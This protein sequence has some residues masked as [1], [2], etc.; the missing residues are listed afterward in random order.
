MTI[1]SPK[2]PLKEDPGSYGV[3][4][5]FGYCL[6]GRVIEKITN[7]LYINFVREEFNVDV[8]LAEKT[9][10]KLLPDE[11]TY[12]SKTMRSAY[13]MNLSRMD[14]CAGL[15]F[16]PHDL[17]K[18]ANQIQGNVSQRG[19]I[20]G[21]ESLLLKRGDWIMVAFANRRKAYLD[22]LPF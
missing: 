17:L 11:N 20:A 8:Q 5:N 13:T 22:A 10:D 3:Y 7:K 9:Y 21:A 14:S 4:S 6:L 12:Y 16:K 2:W 18:L 15:L 19:S 1:D